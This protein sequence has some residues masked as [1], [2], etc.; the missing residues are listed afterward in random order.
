[1]GTIISVIIILVW[2]NSES[3]QYYGKIM[4]IST[5]KLGSENKAK[6]PKYPNLTNRKSKS[7]AFF[8]KTSMNSKN[9]ITINELKKLEEQKRI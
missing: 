6:W 4:T 8:K 2:T 9:N 7:E 5:R 3:A 1:M